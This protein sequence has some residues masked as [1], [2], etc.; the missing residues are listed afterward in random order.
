MSVLGGEGRVNFLGGGLVRVMVVFT[1]RSVSGEDMI[2]ILVV[3][4]KEWKIRD[5][6][7]NG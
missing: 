5:F 3:D 6:G 2:S 4:F 1:E 7:R